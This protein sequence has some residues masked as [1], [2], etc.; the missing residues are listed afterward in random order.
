MA[1][2]PRA[3]HAII[4]GRDGQ[5]LHFDFIDNTANKILDTVGFVTDI[6]YAPSGR[7]IAVGS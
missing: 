3:D 4:G 7:Y 6:K 2:S 5:V 1:L